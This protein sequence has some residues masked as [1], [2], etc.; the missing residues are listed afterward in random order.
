LD[1]IRIQ[2]GWRAIDVGCGPLGILHLLSERVG[3]SGVVVTR[4]RGTLGAHGARP[5]RSASPGQCHRAASRC[6]GKR[7]VEAVL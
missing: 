2:P 4:A 5:D 1:Q 6:P 7:L 3:S